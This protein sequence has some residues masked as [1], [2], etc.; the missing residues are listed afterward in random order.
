[1]QLA[2]RFASA[3]AVVALSMQSKDGMG[4]IVD[5]AV[6]G[7]ENGNGVLFPAAIARCGGG[8]M[9]PRRSTPIW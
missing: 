2:A 3:L 7:A 5:F 8:L 4:W 1:M 9:A 6:I